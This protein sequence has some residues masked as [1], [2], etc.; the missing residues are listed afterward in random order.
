MSS[1]KKPS[2]F[3]RRT[4]WDGM[5]SVLDISGSY[6]RNL[7]YRYCDIDSKPSYLK[8]DKQA[9]HSD[10]AKIGLDIRQAARQYNKEQSYK[11]QSQTLPEN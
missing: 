9:I 11:K 6:A 5:A 4:C 2:S 7:D 3:P 8:S 10:W 1:D